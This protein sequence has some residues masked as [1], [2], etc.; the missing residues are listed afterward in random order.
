LGKAAR[1]ESPVDMSWQEG[2]TSGYVMELDSQLPHHGR[3]RV[4]VGATDREGTA[5][6]SL[7]CLPA[8]LY[9]TPRPVVRQQRP[10]KG[11]QQGTQA[12]RQ[13]G[14]A[15]RRALGNALHFQRV[16]GEGIMSKPCLD[17]SM[18]WGG[19]VRSR[20]DL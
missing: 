11:G 20:G 13:P 6:Y 9:P 5:S 14:D 16:V 4:E 17:P 2:I 10:G 8:Q 3:E 1:K 12:A 18:V 7:V 15:D 19:D